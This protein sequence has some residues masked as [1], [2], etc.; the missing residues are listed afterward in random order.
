MDSFIHITIDGDRTL[1][2][3]RAGR[4]V[5]YLDNVSGAFTFEI[6][7][8]Q[9]NVQIIGAYLGKGSED[10]KLQTTQHHTCPSASSNLLIKGVFEDE[11]KFEYK[12]LIRIEK[13]CNGCHA[14][15]KNHNL[16][17]SDKVTIKT[18]PHLEIL[19]HDVQCAH[20]SA[21]G[22][23][24]KENLFYLS[25]RGITREDSTH[26]LKEGFLSE[27]YDITRPYHP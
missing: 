25:S 3:S 1:T 13:D 12:G 7:S 9:V 5:V 22:G 23:P 18:E 24:N 21:T 11:A 17:L 20:G 19:S 4:Y 16:T 10:K 15:Q 26:L 6:E 2:Y 14:Y 8:P 27:I